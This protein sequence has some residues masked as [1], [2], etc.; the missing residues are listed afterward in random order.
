DARILSNSWGGA[1]Y[2]QA[3]K[4]AVDYAL[5][6]GVVVVVSAGND[7]YA[8]WRR[9]AN[10]PGAIAVAASDPHNRKASFS[11]EGWWVSVA[12]PGVRVLSSVPRTQIQA[13][14]GLPLL[15]DYWDGTSMACPFVSALVAM[16]LEKSP[17]ATPYQVK[18][19]LQATAQDL[20]SPGF[21]PK[22]GHG[23]IQANKALSTALPADNAASLAIYVTCESAPALIG[24]EWPIPTVD[25]TLRKDG[26]IHGYGQTDL[27]GWYYIGFPTGPYGPG[28]GVGLFPVLEP[29]T[30]EIILGGEDATPYW[31]NWRTANR[32]TARTTV[33]LNPGEAKEV[34]LRVSTT[35]KVTLT[36]VGGG[37]DTDIDLAVQ[38][39]DPATGLYVW[40]TPSNPGYWGTF[41]A[42]ASGATGTETYTLNP[43]HWFDDFY[44]LAVLFNG[45]TPATVVVTVE[46]NGVTE[47]Y[48]F[49][50]TTPGAY[51]AY[52]PGPPVSRWPGWWNN[53][54]GP[55]VY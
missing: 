54:A 32:V 5:A 36:W 55:Y 53:Y 4:A 28:Y 10:I 25:I 26:R 38:E 20:E 33:T 45:G 8:L 49:T 21:D 30:Y 15:Y 2:S 44:P 52:S 3:I 42:D 27:E 1:A 47:T 48:S 37:D 14:K 22:T 16:I 17:T 12:A 23:L 40:R 39:F 24:D 46:Q 41:S 43:V 11:T 6:R 13:G 31:A 18:K 35:L 7:T 29:G 50:L 34:V 19:L 9:P 51:P